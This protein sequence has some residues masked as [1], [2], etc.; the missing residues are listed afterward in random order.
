[1][2]T[3]KARLTALLPATPC[4]PDMY[5]R[6]KKIADDA[7][8]SLAEIQRGAFSLFLSSNSRNTGTESSDTGEPYEEVMLPEQ[9]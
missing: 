5:E 4:S 3:K 9:V 1:M 2:R 6:M 7:G 8:E